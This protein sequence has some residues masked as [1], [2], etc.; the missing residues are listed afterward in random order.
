MYCIDSNMAMSNPSFH[1]SSSPPSGGTRTYHGT[2]STNATVMSPETGPGSHDDKSSIA[3]FDLGQ[4][5]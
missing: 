1:L 3:E 2:P 5:K 4:A